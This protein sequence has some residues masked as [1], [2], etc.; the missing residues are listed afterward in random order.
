[1][2]PG[3]GEGL[4]QRLKDE[5]VKPTEFDRR[6]KIARSSVYRVL[7]ATGVIAVTDSRPVRRR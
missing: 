3:S 2:Q 7:E 1:M 6:L 4:G 5:G